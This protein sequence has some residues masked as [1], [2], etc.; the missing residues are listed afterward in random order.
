L[1]LA[2]EQETQRLIYEAQQQ[3]KEK[4][5]EEGEEQKRWMESRGSQAN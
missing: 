4:H 5:E 3:Q 2:E 1:A